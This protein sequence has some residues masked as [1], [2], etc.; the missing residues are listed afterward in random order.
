MYSIN[1]HDDPIN[2]DTT[3]HPDSSKNIEPP[4]LMPRYNIPHPKYVGNQIVQ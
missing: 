4:F 1:F 2:Y 3:V